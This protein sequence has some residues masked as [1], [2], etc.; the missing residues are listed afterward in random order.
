M[1]NNITLLRPEALTLLRQEAAW[2]EALRSYRPEGGAFASRLISMAASLRKCYPRLATRSMVRT[3]HTDKWFLGAGF[4]GAP[5]ISHGARAQA[6]AM[7]A[8]AAS[9]ES[10]TYPCVCAAAPPS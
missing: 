7:P 4:L 3:V 1:E 5:L 6:S 9:R 2:V 10:Q 8:R